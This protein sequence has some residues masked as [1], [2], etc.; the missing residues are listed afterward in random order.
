MSPV[1]R[2]TLKIVGKRQVSVVKPVNLSPNTIGS[3]VG[4][5]LNAANAEGEAHL[6]AEQSWNAAKFRS[7]PG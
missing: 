7:I 4:G 3:V 5:F 6:K 1:V 2:P